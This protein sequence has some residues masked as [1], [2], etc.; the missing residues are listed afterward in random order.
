[1]GEK[2]RVVELTRGTQRLLGCVLRLR[3]VTGVVQRAT[4]RRTHAYPS[5]GGEIVFQRFG[6]QRHGLVTEQARP[7][8]RILERHRRTHERVPVAVRTR[9]VAGMTHRREGREVVARE[10]LGF[11]LGEQQLEL[12][13]G[14]SI[15]RAFEDPQR[16][17]IV[18]DGRYEGQHIDGA[19]RRTLRIVEGTL[20]VVGAARGGVVL[21]QRAEMLFKIPFVASF[22]HRRDRRVQ[23]PAPRRAQLGGEGIADERMRESKAIEPNFDDNAHA[24]RLLDPVE[25][26]RVVDTSRVGGHVE[27]KLETHERRHLQELLRTGIEATDAAP[28]RGAH[29]GGELA[30][31]RPVGAHR[32]RYRAEEQWVPGGL[33]G[34]SGN[35]G[36]R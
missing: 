32:G 3:A 33:V 36:G 8:A 23:S 6:E 7:P 12:H 31:Q 24:H 10:P 16:E 14:G 21:R 11:S 2:L 1:M 26:D 13:R 9:D 5:G 34:E 35:G 18:L 15:P 28:D 17:R 19:T 20:V 29:V 30:R 4:V 25:T 27:R 22:D